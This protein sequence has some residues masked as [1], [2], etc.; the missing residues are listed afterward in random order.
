MFDYLKFINKINEKFKSYLKFLWNCNFKI[1]AFIFKF[2]YFWTK[3][4]V[5]ILLYIKIW[6]FSLTLI[7][8]W[9]FTAY[10]RSICALKEFL[11]VFYHLHVLRV[12]YLDRWR[13][14]TFTTVDRHFKHYLK[15][16]TFFYTFKKKVLNFGL[17]IFKWFRHFGMSWMQFNYFL[18]N[19]CLY[20]CDKN[21]VGLL[22]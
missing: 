8:M 16:I 5:R 11:H 19:V 4:F 7:T 2:A 20:E 18:E 21:F 22:I 3:I 1:L 14:I 10:P 13:Y 15:E 12:F 6:I 9:C 17:P